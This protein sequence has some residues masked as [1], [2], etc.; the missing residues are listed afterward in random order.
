MGLLA[1]SPSLLDAF[2]WWLHSEGDADAEARGLAELVAKVKREPSRVT[3]AMQ[4]GTAWHSAIEREPETGADVGITLESG[5]AYR[6]SLEA[7][8]EARA[9]FPQGTLREVEARLELPAIGVVLNVRADAVSGNEVHEVKTSED[10]FDATKCDRL[11]HATQWRAYLLAFE[12]SVVTY[13]LCRLAFDE[14]AGLYRLR[15]HSTMRQYPYPGMRADLEDV[16][17]DCATFIRDNGLESYR[18]EREAA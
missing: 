13:H 8:A 1:L 18:L 3:P 17:R 12:A 6:F 16:A 11:T 10:D 4:L 15:E 14:E 5:A 7:V 2:E 9:A